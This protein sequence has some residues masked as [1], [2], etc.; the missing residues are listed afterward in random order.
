MTMPPTTTSDWP[1]RIDRIHDVGCSDWLT[2]AW[3]AML[4]R[5]GIV[6]EEHASDVARVT[7][8]M[9]DDDIVTWREG[10][11]YR[12]QEW[13]IE[14]LGEEAGGSLMV[15]R[16]VPP[17]EQMLQVRWQLMKCVCQI[18]DMQ[19]ALLDAAEEYADAIMPGYTHTR[20]AQPTTFGHY[21]LSVL[22][23][24]VRSAEIV[25]SGYHYMNLN[26]M[27][28]GALAGTSFP[29]DRDLV[30]RYLGMDGL[31]E[32]AND[33][34]SYTDGYL[35][36]VCGLVNVANAVSRMATDLAYWSGDEFGFL[37]MGTHGV[38]FMMPQK[39][40]NPNSLERVRLYSGQMIGALTSVAVAGLREPQADTH[41]M[42]HLEDATLQA[43]ELAGR[44]FP[45]VTKEM[46][47]MEVDRER[48]RAVVEDS[49]I[50]STELANQFVRE[51]GVDYRT[52][53]EI[54]KRFVRASEGAGVP[55]SQARAEML[56]E[57]AE[58]V[59]GRRLGITDE[60]LRELLDP[61]H[62]IEVTDSKGGVAPAEM[63][64]MIADRQE[65][66]ETARNRHLA[67]IETL[68]QA[69]ARMVADLQTV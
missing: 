15:G 26:E 67:R 8:E 61:A 68:E 35:V 59:L 23:A 49:Y 6:P 55:A 44:V 22:D 57:V 53:H 52:G 17:G 12:R 3:I 50:A 25:D 46:Q 66:L 20:H 27:G 29:I 62:F 33:A 7:L 63:A 60:R 42:L 43:I 30:S 28:A 32:N 58:E 40:T 65:R 1:D 2:A 31:I 56:E 19:D 51:Y 45:E 34:V 4:L 48:M 5:Q 64:R 39:T 47:R 21:L 69:Q 16:T 24:V 41:A 37:E 54:I 38:S 18:L 11:F 10:Y 36:V 9:L 13:L 14:R